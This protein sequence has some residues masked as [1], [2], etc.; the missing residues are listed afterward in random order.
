M[1]A[2]SMSVQALCDKTGMSY[3]TALMLYRS[4]SL[5]WDFKTIDNM[6]KALDCQPGDLIEYLPEEATQEAS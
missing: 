6:C 1:D 2:K 3:N 4:A 5:R